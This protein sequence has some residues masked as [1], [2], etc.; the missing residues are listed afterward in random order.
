MSFKDDLVKSD[1]DFVVPIGSQQCSNV[2]KKLVARIG[3]RG[4]NISNHTLR[5][6]FAKQIWMNKGENEASLILLSEI[7]G[8]SSTAITRTYLGISDR[9]IS[10]AYKTLSLKPIK[11]VSKTNK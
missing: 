4:V 9:E 10:D 7:L 5:K 1:T 11:S 8:H 2:L 3:V 6:T